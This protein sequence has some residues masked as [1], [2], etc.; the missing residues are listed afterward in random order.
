MPNPK[1]PP[2]SLVQLRSAVWTGDTRDTRPY[3]TIEVG[4]DM[5]DLIVNREAANS[6]SLPPGRIVV[7]PR[8][9][10]WRTGVSSL[11]L[12]RSCRYENHV[13][14]CPCQAGG[15]QRFVFEGD[16]GGIREANPPPL[17]TCGLKQP[18]STASIH[19]RGSLMSSAASPKPWNS[20]GSVN[21]VSKN[22]AYRRG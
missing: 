19:K 2:S 13:D 18:S 4:Q 10:Q 16:R 5:I 1:G 3:A 14:L 6:P 22:T 11:A 12:G 9:G 15:Q 20:L 7:A 8:P 17:P 21:W